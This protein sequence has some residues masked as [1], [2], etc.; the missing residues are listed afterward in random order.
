MPSIQQAIENTV[1][2]SKFM[3]YSYSLKVLFDEQFESGS[4]Y[5]VQFSH[6]LFIRRKIFPIIRDSCDYVCPYKKQY[7]G[8]QFLDFIEKLYQF[9]VWLVE[10]QKMFFKYFYFDNFRFNHYTRYSIKDK[11]FK[12]IGWDFNV[13]QP[14]NLSHLTYSRRMSYLN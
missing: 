8:H 4:G 11:E 1:I 7:E 12:I 6:I 3:Q 5:L 14:K 13:R 10:D 9:M 2:A